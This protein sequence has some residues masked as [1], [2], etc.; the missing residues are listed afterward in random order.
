[1]LKET[2]IFKEIIEL[3]MPQASHRIDLLRKFVVVRLFRNKSEII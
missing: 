2:L 3:K 1:M